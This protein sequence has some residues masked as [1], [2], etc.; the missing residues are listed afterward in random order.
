MSGDMQ[1]T[2]V[3]LHEA[4]DAL[5]TDRNGIYVD[6]TFGRGGHSRLILDRLGPDGRLIAFDRDPAAVAAA[7]NWSDARFEIIHA[8]F[9]RMQETLM[10]R[11][12]QRINGILMDLGVS[13]PQLDEAGRGF[14][15][16]AS[17]PLDMRMD[18]TRGMT[19]QEWLAQASEREL[20]G[21]LREYGE[22][23][24]AGRI[25]R[26]IVQA[27]QQGPLADTQQLA[28]LVAAAVPTREPGKHPATRTFQ[29]I[30]MLVNRELD[31]L[32]RVL[33]Q[34][35]ALLAP[36]GRLVI[37][38]FHSLEDRLVKR[39]MREA[40]RADTLPAKLPVRQQDVYAPKMKLIG[41]AQRPGAKEIELNPRS[42]SA[43][44]RVAERTTHL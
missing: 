6:A 34:A 4:V 30:R 29:A 32:E 41:K 39:F 14:S 10:G 22:E 5:V 38:S 31:E 37:I 26:A 19:A 40:A 16:R 7:Q 35:L 15:F 11:G 28:E 21:V 12:L 2:T 1:H 18:T 24:F 17:G 25:A 33:P 36:G 3:L 13:S 42:R 9:A 44:M 23:R 27:R 8:P 20:A 43:V